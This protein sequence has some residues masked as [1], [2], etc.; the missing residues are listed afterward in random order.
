MWQ[1]IDGGPA[2]VLVTTAR[3]PEAWLPDGQL[4]TYITLKEGQDYDIWGYTVAD[5]APR[6]VVS[7]PGS[8]QM[9]SRFSPDGRWIAYESNDSGEYEVYVEPYPPSGV[10][11]RVSTAGGHRPVWSPDGGELYFDD[12]GRLY[13][14]RVR[15][16]PRVAIEPPMPLPIAGFVQNFG[17]RTYDITPDGQR[18]L[19][20]FPPR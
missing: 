14:S 17:R 7:L 3:A 11:T 19:M 1:P 6:A 20:L 8:A 15:L 12:D 16:E 13:V 4:F 10:R 2:D 18:F 5:R 9:S